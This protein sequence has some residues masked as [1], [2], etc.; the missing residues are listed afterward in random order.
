MLSRGFEGWTPL[1]IA[2]YNGCPAVLRH[3]L[4][5]PQAG[6]DEGDEKGA[7]ALWWAAVH[8]RPDA[9]RCVRVLLSFLG[10]VSLACWGEGGIGLA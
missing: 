7:T 10:V 1:I 5:H 6:L 3:L 2:G 8:N 4:A 9:V